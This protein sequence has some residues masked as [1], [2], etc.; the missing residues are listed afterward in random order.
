MPV[1]PAAARHLSSAAKAAQEHGYGGSKKKAP[2]RTDDT[3]IATLLALLDPLLH[4]FR[5][6][7]AAKALHAEIEKSEQDTKGWRPS[8]RGAASSS[9]QSL[10]CRIR[11]I[12]ILQF[13]VIL[14]TSWRPRP[15]GGDHSSRWFLLILLLLPVL[16]LAL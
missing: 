5:E 8:P 3:A 4:A 13:L 11:L 7:A 15:F 16:E 10:H 1:L 2:W 14:L 9:L 6:S 12:F